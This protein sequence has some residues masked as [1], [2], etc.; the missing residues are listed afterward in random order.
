[1]IAVSLG[2]VALPLA[3]LL[4]LAG[5]WGASWLAERLARHQGCADAAAV[6]NAVFVAAGL[7]LLAARLGHVARQA[8]LYADAP[9]AVLDVR[10]GGWLAPAGVVAGL[11]WLLWRGLRRPGWRAALAAGVLA[12]AA[13]W[14][15]A[16][17]VLGVNDEPS[18]P[19][20]SLAR[21]GGGAHVS[22]PAELAGGQ[23]TVLNL[24]ASWCGPC[25]AEMPVLAAA[26]QRE[27]G[28]VRF[29]FVNQG[30]STSA[31]QAYLTDQDL[32]LQ[33]VLLDPAA[34]LG[35][36]MGSRGLPTTLFFDARG[37]LVD[38]HMGVLTDVALR[39]R[40]RHLAGAA[41]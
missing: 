14:G 11:G 29:L 13:A 1:M 5:V 35:P 12:G 27:A 16:T 17:Q 37:R 33:D 15:S 40:L 31:A 9:W 41:G 24:W 18:M 32:A 39:A 21:L 2:P 26:Q 28:R 20:L 7:G 25:R 19:A 34:R 23:P 10:D 8:D 22:L 3:P 30:E 4:L 38:R 6:G 36:A